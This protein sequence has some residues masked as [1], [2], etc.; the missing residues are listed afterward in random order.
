[1]RART[2]TYSRLDLYLI[3]ERRGST[4]PTCKFGS[5]IKRPGTHTSWK[6]KSSSSRDD[7]LLRLRQSIDQLWPCFLASFFSWCSWKANPA[8][9]TAATA[10]TS[11]LIRWPCSFSGSFL[12]LCFSCCSHMHRN[13]SMHA[14]SRAE[15]YMHR[16]GDRSKK[17]DLVLTKAYAPAAMAP[18]SPSCSMCL[19][20]FSF[21]S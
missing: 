1:M 14:R 7:V 12:A 11:S 6:N 3:Q 4:V 10:A 2:H 21:F 9:P 19:W 20:C 13:T 18:N 8:E 15:S 16:S 17:L 5:P